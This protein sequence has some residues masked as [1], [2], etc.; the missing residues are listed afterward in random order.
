[1]IFNQGIDLPDFASFP[2]LETPQGLGLIDG[3]YRQLIELGKTKNIGVILDGVTWMANRDRAKNLGYTPDDLQKINAH[4]I[5]VMRQARD[6]YGD[7]PTIISGNIGPRTDAYLAVEQMSIEQSQHYHAEQIGFMA[8][9][10]ADI[11]TACTL[12]YVNEAIGLALAAKAVDMPIVISFTLEI[13]GKLPSGMALQD[14]IEQVEAA[15]ASYPLY[16]MINCAHPE[17]FA[18]ILDGGPWMSKLRG[19]VVNASKCSH[20]ELDKATTLDDGNPVELGASLQSL[21]L[22]H[23]N[24]TVLGGCCGTDMRHLSVM[25]K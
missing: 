14:A 19:L 3:Y 20:A 6:D 8:T 21:S 12:A 18:D 16:Y 17:H 4:A 2:L 11:I 13:D 23:K 24:I 10:K 15:T 5:E 25:F 7:V 22:A 1:M 9:S